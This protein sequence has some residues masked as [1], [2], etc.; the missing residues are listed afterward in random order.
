MSQQVSIICGLDVAR[1]A[2]ITSGMLPAVLFAILFHEWHVNFLVLL[3]ITLLAIVVLEIR[4]A[5]ARCN[6]DIV[7]LH[8]S[9]YAGSELE[10]SFLS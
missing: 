4:M 5:V 9:D 2:F 1:S 3:A 10:E 7:R 6:K 8:I